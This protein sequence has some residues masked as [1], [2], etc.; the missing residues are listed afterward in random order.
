MSDPASRDSSVVAA[1]LVEAAC[2]AQ[3]GD[4]EAAK[5]HIAHAVAILDGQPVPIPTTGQAIRAIAR[6]TPRGGLAA[7]QAHR[8]VEHVDANLCDKIYIEDLAAL[9]SLSSSHFSRAFTRT[10]GISAHA[11]LTRRRI[12]AA[13][14]LLLTTDAPLCEIAQICGMSDQSH[15]ISLFRR[16]VGETPHFWRRSRQAAVEEQVTKLPRA[17]A[18]QSTVWEAARAKADNNRASEPARARP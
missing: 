14:A 5:A 16:L 10:F 4:G 17:H 15:L 2:R 18:D 1:Q 13:Q 6:Q 8:V 3:D 12:E 11:W 7:W 9:L